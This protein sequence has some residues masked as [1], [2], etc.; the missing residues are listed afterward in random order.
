MARL[1][2]DSKPIAKGFRRTDMLL[3]ACVDDEFLLF[4]LLMNMSLQSNLTSIIALLCCPF[5][6]NYNESNAT[7]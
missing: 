1:N 4:C 3:L 7:R 2:R 5:T 6:Q